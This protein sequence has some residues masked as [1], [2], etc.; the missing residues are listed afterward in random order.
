MQYFPSLPAE[1]KGGGD[2][3][4]SLPGWSVLVSDWSRRVINFQADFPRT[5]APCS[6]L[7]GDAQRALPECCHRP[8]TS[9]EKAFKVALMAKQSSLFSFFTKSPPPVSRSKPSPSPTEAD[10]PSSVARSNSSPK[11]QAKEKPQQKKA[12]TKGVTPKNNPKPPKPGLNTLF[13]DKA[14]AAKPK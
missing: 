5:R 13:S 9:A 10:L 14:P 7:L 4:T 2:F 12:K 6:C 3:S 8:T 11:E 1:R